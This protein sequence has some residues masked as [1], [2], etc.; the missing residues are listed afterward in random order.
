M[1]G[2]YLLLFLSIYS[3]LIITSCSNEDD[4]EYVG[5]WVRVSDLDGKPRSN[6]SS[7]V[8]GSKG[9]LTGGYDG[10]S[11][12]NDLWEYDPDLNYWT[13]KATMPSTKRSSAVA[14][15]TILLVTLGHK[16]PIS[17]ELADMLL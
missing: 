2:K 17:Q 12:Y 13:Q 4:D 10:D 5:N 7:F 9:Y 14:F 1:K 15:S 8:I 3:L 16:L 11:Y 6:A